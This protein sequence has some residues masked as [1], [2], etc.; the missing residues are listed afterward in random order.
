MQ[1]RYDIPTLQINNS[2][3]SNY[4]LNLVCMLLIKKNSDKR[5]DQQLHKLP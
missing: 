3:S 4:F 5:Q 2:H 1:T